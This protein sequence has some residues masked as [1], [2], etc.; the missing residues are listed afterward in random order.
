M[1][2]PAGAGREGHAIAHAQWEGALPCPGPLGL[3][4]VVVW[5]LAHG[6]SSSFALPSMS[7]AC[8]LWV[9]WLSRDLLPARVRTGPWPV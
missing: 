3:L 6:R 2:L 9:A 7:K 1:C 5:P 8:S 4:G